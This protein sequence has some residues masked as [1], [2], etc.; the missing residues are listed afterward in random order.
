MPAEWQ[1]ETLKIRSGLKESFLILEKRPAPEHFRVEDLFHGTG[2]K[3]IAMQVKK[4]SVEDT[5]LKSATREFLKNGKTGATMRAIAQG[6][7]YSVGL[8][9]RYYPNKS[10][11]YRAVMEKSAGTRNGDILKVCEKVSKKGIVWL[12]KNLPDDELKRLAGG[13]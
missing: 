6:A 8:A 12:L 11:L 2:F 1:R 3:E 13:K 7:G 10:D 4:Q 9:Y 5:I